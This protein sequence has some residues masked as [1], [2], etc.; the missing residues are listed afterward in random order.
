MIGQMLQQRE[1]NNTISPYEVN[2]NTDWDRY[3]V[4]VAQ[5][6]RA[7]SLK[8]PGETTITLKTYQDVLMMCGAPWDELA[9]F[10]VSF[11]LNGI[12]MHNFL[13]WNHEA[14]KVDLMREVQYNA[15]CILQTHRQES[16]RLI[17]LWREGNLEPPRDQT[18]SNEVRPSHFNV[19][20]LRD[21]ER[22]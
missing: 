1:S 4:Q 6:G 18:L 13:S 12:I 9:A 2:M 8:P 16:Y 22:K 15:S 11:S 17:H 20:P 21:L 5:A 14:F 3:S 19:Q 10:I 7:L